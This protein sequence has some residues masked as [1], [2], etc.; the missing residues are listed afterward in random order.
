[1]AV[2][3]LHRTNDTSHDPN[4]YLTLEFMVVCGIAGACV[5]WKG[6]A[7]TGNGEMGFVGGFAG[8]RLALSVV[9]KVLEMLLGLFVIGC[10]IDLAAAVFRSLPGSCPPPEA[11]GPTALEGPPWAYCVEKTLGQEQYG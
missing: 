1:V 7:G 11:L 2:P 8:R 6:F 5:T 9:K 10:V 4:W 3:N